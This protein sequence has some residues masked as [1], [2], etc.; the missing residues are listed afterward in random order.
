VQAAP[1]P[2]GPWPLVGLFPCVILLF[3]VGLM[4]FELIQGM[5]GYHKTGKITGLVIDPIARIFDDQLPK[6]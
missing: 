3:V 6:E 2:W 4:G 1:V 5:W